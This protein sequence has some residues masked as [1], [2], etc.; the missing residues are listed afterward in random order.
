MSFYRTLS[1]DRLNWGTEFIYLLSVAGLHLDLS[2]SFF[3]SFLLKEGT[4]SE[5]HIGDLENKFIV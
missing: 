3:L 2:I 5:T 1:L 4:K